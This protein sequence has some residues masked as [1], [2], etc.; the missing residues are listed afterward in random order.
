MSFIDDHDLAAEYAID[1]NER[2]REA[3]K[4]SNTELS[5]LLIEESDKLDKRFKKMIL[6][7]CK[8]CAV[9]RSSISERQRHVL[10][11]AYVYNFEVD[12]G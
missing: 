4:Y 10:I 8:T 7:I 2:F 1:V 5:E 11:K 12:R 9:D 3:D 6:N